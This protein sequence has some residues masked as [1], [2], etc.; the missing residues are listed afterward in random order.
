M[1]NN[2]ITKINGRTIMRG[3][4][5]Y[6]TIDIESAK[7]IKDDLWIKGFFIESLD[8]W[9]GKTRVRN[10]HELRQRD[11]MLF[12]L[13]DVRGKKILD[14]GCGQAEYL[15]VIGRMGAKFVAGQD[16]DEKCITSGR[17]RLEKENIEGKL[18]VG[19]ATEIKFPSNYFDSVFSADFFEHISL[20]QKKE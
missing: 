5:T 12:T 1:L 15:T 4:K 6:H 19:D 20:Q 14:I 8:N 10:F 16:L 7:K 13:G 17:A 9:D 18:I 3:W 11:L 2:L